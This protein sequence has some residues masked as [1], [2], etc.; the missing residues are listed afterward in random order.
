MHP[1]ALS[2]FSAMMMSAGLAS[3]APAWTA[4]VESSGR[5]SLRWADE[6]RAE[7][8]PG[9]FEA[10]WRGATLSKPNDWNAGAGPVCRGSIRAPGGAT[11]ECELRSAPM[12]DGIHLT[13]TLRPRAVV[14]L[15][16]L[17]I[18]FDVPA[19]RLAGGTFRVDEHEGVFPEQFD[20]G[21]HLH[22]TQ[23]AKRV[24][25]RYPDGRNLQFAFRTAVPVLVQDNRKWGP[26][27]SIRIGPQN[28]PP[29]TWKSEESFTVDA[30]LSSADGIRLEYEQPVVIRTD[31]QWIPLKVELDIEPGSA[32][33][34]SQ[35]GR[36][37]PPAGKHGWLIARPDGLLA[38]E[39]NPDRPLRF[40]GVNL[41]FSAQ[42]L[43]HEEA[44]RL[45][46]RLQR[47]GYNA[48]R[49]HHYEGLLVRR[50]A[51]D[52]V[53]L[54]ADALDRLDYLFAAFKKRG[55]YVTTDLYVS[56]PVQ[57][58]EIW[59]GARGRVE[60]DEFKMLIPVNRRAFENWKTFARNL[61][62]HTN[63]YTGLAWGRDPALAWLSMINEGNFG[64]FIGR[65]SERARKDWTV[66]WNQWLHRT[67]PNAAAL[68]AAWARDDAAAMYERHAIPLVS[69]R[70]A[71]RPDAR[72][73]ARFLVDTECEMIRR[74]RDFLRNEIGCRALITNS[75]GWS[76]PLPWQAARLEYDYVDD[77][78]YVDH[79]HF[80]ERPWRLP[81]RCAQTNPVTRGVPGGAH[82]AFVRLTDRPFTIS[83]YNYAAPSRYRGIGGILTG[84]M[85]ALQGWS[86]IWR[87]AYSHNRKN[88]F[89]PQQT[90]YFDLAADPINQAADRAALCLFLRG[91]MQS[92]PHTVAIAADP[93]TLRTRPVHLG[94]VAPSWTA[95]AGVT[96]VG[97]YLQAASRR[98]SVPDLLLPVP[99]N[100]PQDLPADRILNVEPYDSDAAARILAAMRE[101]GW[102]APG[103]R[104][105]LAAHR[106]ESETGEL[107]MDG[108]ERILRIVT[109]RTVGVWAEAGRTVAAGS[110][111]F[112]ILDTEATVFVTSL[113]GRPVPESRRLLI[114]HLTEQQNSGIRFA[115]R[116]R[117]ILLAWGALPHLV[118]RGRARVVFAKS[119]AGRAE[120]W[121]L[122][123]GGRRVAQVPIL[124]DAS[125]RMEID[126]DVAGT[127]G[128]RLLYELVIRP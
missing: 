90:G 9:L 16:S 49:L 59:P 122:S 35:F 68:A 89:Q 36:F 70:Y 61:L 32:L 47:L 14:K 15:N 114:T 96:R 117:T 126:L 120:A 25:V 81:S 87:F 44:D 58:A 54:D 73:F 22:A 20:N 30:I 76:N 110:I 10:G 85:G 17:H 13:W 18:S 39:K 67:Y 107:L 57:A 62:N 60:M 43:P 66:A 42:Y 3:A 8:V 11:V 95:L 97:T 109:P 65:L 92:A 124:R 27:F 19:D 78:F 123:T 1:C 12:Q 108:A 118:R 77:H 28:T 84:A 51:G 112:T 102:L 101:R 105:D 106:I 7:L 53:H 37:D 26:S 99:G 34:F 119:A 6:E 4:R 55:I 64:N 103:N 125:G 80:L 33:D 88:L 46:E 38:F 93:K 2:C 100:A 72:D 104:T 52:S 111:E 31:S 40:Y 116:D 79:P 128:A 82:C 45:A 21:V 63:P 71:D 91:D 86:V 23:K 127:D 29:R 113:D 75:N 94:G 5:I 41:C 74:M 69:D 48:V 98:Q 56:R 83:E 50:G 115:D 121:A 24:V